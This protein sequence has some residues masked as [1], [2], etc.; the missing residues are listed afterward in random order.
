M[1]LQKSYG[2][3]L[4]A[5]I[6][7]VLSSA[8]ANISYSQNFTPGE[9]YYDSTGYIEYRAGNLPIILSSP[10]GGDLKPDNVSDRDCAGCK[11]VKDRFTKEITESLYDDF[12]NTTGLYPHVIINSLHRIKL[13]ANRG[14]GDAADGDPIAEEAWNEYHNFIDIAK[15]TITE[16]QERGLFLDIHGHAH[17]IQRIEVGYL[18]SSSQL[19]LSDTELDTDILIEKNS[20]RTLVGD[21]IQNLSHSEL[22]RGEYSFGS[23]MDDRGFPSVPSLSDPFP[24]AD[25]P[26]FIGGYNIQRHGSI[27]NNGLIDAIQLELNSEI[28]F[29]SDLRELL[30][31]SLRAS[32]NDYI[33]LHYDNQYLSVNDVDESTQNFKLYPNPSSNYFSIDGDLNATEIIIYNNLG[34][35]VHSETFSENIVNVDFLPKGFYFVQLKKENAILD[36]LKLIKN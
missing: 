34:Q 6:I 20:I 26:Y 29:D 19:R 25:E 1:K 32:T 3:N 7:L 15:A 31:T 14:I 21:N 33:T 18:L 23:I 28:R 5:S 16:D 10:H 36:S 35:I 11:Y 27:S 17:D 4:I 9:I 22:L 2:Y 8:I 13:D 24:N 12:V 30:I